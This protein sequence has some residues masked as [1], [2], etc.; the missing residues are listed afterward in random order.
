MPVAEMDWT[1]LLLGGA[2]R[3]QVYNRP[4]AVTMVPRSTST[5]PTVPTVVVDDGPDI[6]LLVASLRVAAACNAFHS[7]L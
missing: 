1:G 5:L 4:Q 3:L 2:L 7:L 6:R